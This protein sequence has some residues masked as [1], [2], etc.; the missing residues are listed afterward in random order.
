MLCIRIVSLAV[1][2]VC[3]VVAIG[4]AASEPPADFRLEWVGRDAQ[5]HA[6]M[7]DILTIRGKHLPGNELEIQYLEAYCRDGSRELEWEDTKI[8]HV[9]ELVESDRD[10]RQLRLRCTLKDGVTVDHLIR[11][12]EDGVDFQ[13]EAYNPTE[14]ASS[15]HWA[16]PCIRV[17]NFTGAGAED[18]WSAEPKYIHKCFL[19]LDNQLTRMPTT[20]WTIESRRTP[21]QV[22]V[23]SGVNRNDVNARPLNDRVP[24]NGLIGCFSADETV[25]MATAWQP[26]Q[27]LF[28]GVMGCIHSDFRI[29]GLQP[30]ERKKI[31]GRIY[32]MENDVEKL[33]EHYHRDFPDS[34]SP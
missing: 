8:G 33:L 25:L 17:G 11:A 4:A 21:G 30:G 12:V 24:S 7:N 32:L 28:Q 1:C 34:Q 2:I 15:A 27:E 22:W 3:G 13:L 5:R 31:H 19:F 6:G 18:A 26:Y 9:T 23:P 20:P 16:Q 29:G 14:H 10:G